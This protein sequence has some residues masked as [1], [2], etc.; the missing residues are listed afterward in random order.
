MRVVYRR[1]R[2]VDDRPTSGDDASRPLDVLNGRQREGLVTPHA[3][4][5]SGRGVAEYDLAEVSRGVHASRV[6]KLILQPLHLVPRRVRPRDL[7]GSDT[8]HTAIL[9]WH[10]HPLE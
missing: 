7:T 9:E 8:R 6:S 1:F 5:D 2:L 4:R 10:R 3:A